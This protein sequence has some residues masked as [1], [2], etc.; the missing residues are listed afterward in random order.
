MEKVLD[1]YMY[2]DNSHSIFHLID[3]KAHLASLTS[4]FDKVL[5][6]G[7]NISIIRQNYTATA[8][9]FDE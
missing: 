5:Y 7:L 6:I 3:N 4:H 1:M 9:S 2:Y 8:V